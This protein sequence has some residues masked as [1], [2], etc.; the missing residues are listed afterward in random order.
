LAV[1]DSIKINCHLIYGGD[2]STKLI[3][4]KD[5]VEKSCKNTPKLKCEL[6]AIVGRDGYRI[7][8]PEEIEVI[9]KCESK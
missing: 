7:L 5:L 2:V 4:L 6:V 9:I 1:L 8:F 3:L